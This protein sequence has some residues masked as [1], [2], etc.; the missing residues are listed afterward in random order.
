MKQDLEVV[1]SNVILANE[2]IDAHDPSDP[3]E[4]N[5]TIMDVVNS[6]KTME[7]K[8]MEIITKIKHEDMMNFC[9]LLNDDVQKTINRYRKLKHG[10]KPEKFKRQCLLEEE[11]AKQAASPEITIPKSEPAPRASPPKQ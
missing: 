10:R 8:L 2:M 6:I 4:E 1:V 11:E 9:L 5:E 3:V 7:K